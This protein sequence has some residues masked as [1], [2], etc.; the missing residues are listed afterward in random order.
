MKLKETMRRL[1]RD[2]EAYAFAMDYD[3]K[4]ELWSRIDRLERVVAEINERTARKS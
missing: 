3:E 1:W 2:I 4:D